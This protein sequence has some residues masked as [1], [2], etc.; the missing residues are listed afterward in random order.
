MSELFYEDDLQLHKDKVKSM[1]LKS[2]LGAPLNAS[3]EARIS[4]SWKSFLDRLT[5][6]V[7][8]PNDDPIGMLET[9]AEIIGRGHEV[10]RTIHDS[11]S[12]ANRRAFPAS[13]E[14]RAKNAVHNALADL[15]AL[16]ISPSELMEALKDSA[17]REAI[18]KLMED[19][20]GD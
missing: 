2:T 6:A 13:R 1:T 10:Q 9:V 16:G 14:G 7:A 3:E 20:R 5:E 8:C 18:D 19:S 4:M 12:S 11:W 17:T 15:S